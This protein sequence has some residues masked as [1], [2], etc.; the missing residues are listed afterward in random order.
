M[1]LSDETA[2]RG[3]APR[4]RGASLGRRL[5]GP[6]RLGRGEAALLKLMSPLAMVVVAATVLCCVLGF[7]LAKQA[8][9]YLE[10]A[11]RQALRGA[12][13]ALQAVSPDLTDVDP[14]LIHI[15]ESASGLKGLR[16]AEEPPEGAREVQS[17]IDSN[18]RIV[19]WFT[20]EAERPATAMVTRLL[21][22]GGLI[23]LGLFGFALLAMWQLRRL[24][25][26]L[27]QST[28]EVQRLAYEDP[29]TG[30]PNLHRMR[31]VIEQSL[32]KRRPDEL[33]AVA[34]MDLG[35]F[36]EMK[37]AIGDA[38]EDEVLTEIANRL[39]RDVPEG[40]LIARLR[41][42]KFGLVMRAASVEEA[43]AVVQA[44]RDAISRAIW[45]DQVVQ[46]S[47]NAGLA[48][49][50]RDGADARRTHAPRRPRAARRQAA[51][52]RAHHAVL[53]RHGGRFRRAAL[54]QARAV[55]GD[56]DALVRGPLSADRE[57]GRRR[58]RRRR[59]AAALEPSEPRLYPAGPV[60]AGRGG[61][62][63]DGPARRV[64][65]APRAR[66][67]GALAGPLRRGQP[68]AGAGARPP[69]RRPGRARC[70]PRPRS[71][72]PA[73]CWRSPKAC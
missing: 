27:A 25:K 11:H 59:V 63:A 40:V 49:A 64:R 33:V 29:V 8:D 18:G 28:R 16:L 38:G 7:V 36:D 37:D 1:E 5:R 48:M 2:N 23:A 41:G 69:V 12:I 51:R 15:L 32:A 43:L 45:V 26:L 42:D 67:R 50:P 54:H 61:R 6:A 58:H 47:A 56:R 31:E 72:P 17:L 34:L 55:E 65:A 66:R 20:W 3:P 73:W 70:S 24:D 71:I 60:R 44:T 39:R 53:A 57:G 19:G 62:R 52:P 30:L 4:S 35:G 68:L 14:K 10:N 9:D 21:P 13:E 46:V 22:F